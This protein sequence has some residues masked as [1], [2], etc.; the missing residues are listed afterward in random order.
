MNVYS[1]ASDYSRRKFDY[2]DFMRK[3]QAEGR[4]TAY[5]SENGNPIYAVRFGKSPKLIISFSGNHGNETNAINGG[6]KM[7]LMLSEGRLDEFL[8]DASYVGVP[9]LNPDGELLNQ[10]ENAKG[11]NVNRDFSGR[12][13]MHIFGR[14][15]RTKEALAAK[16]IIDENHPAIVLDHHDYGMRPSEF[17]THE[18][19]TP[20]AEK[21]ALDVRAAVREWGGYVEDVLA[22]PKLGPSRLVGYASRMEIPSILFE[23]GIFL[24]AE[25]HIIADVET[26]KSFSESL[27]ARQ[28][29]SLSSPRNVPSSM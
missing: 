15:F 2:A 20:L 5:P 28:K 16:R 27:R 8:E 1:L 22:Y 23:S 13:P 3:M 19:G 17:E 10:R 14:A 12:G 24:G 25:P 6:K 11:I 26:M 9:C 4:V 7:L 18:S 29:R 21:I